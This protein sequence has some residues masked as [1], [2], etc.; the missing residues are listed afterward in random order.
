MEPLSLHSTYRDKPESRMK[1]TFGRETVDELI[2]LQRNII[3]RRRYCICIRTDINLYI[4]LK[5][6]QTITI[7][8]FQTA[9]F[10]FARNLLILL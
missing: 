2:E 7:H 8:L 1:L 5:T 3:N 4:Q 10:L 9:L 6:Q